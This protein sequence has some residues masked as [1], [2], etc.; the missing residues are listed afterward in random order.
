MIY[1]TRDTPTPALWA[2]ESNRAPPKTW[3]PCTRAAFIAAWEA[4]DGRRFATLI[5]WC[6]RRPLVQP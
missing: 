3:T 5:A 6:Q 2:S 1:A 4:R